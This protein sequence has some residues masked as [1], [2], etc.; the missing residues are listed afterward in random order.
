MLVD[1][2]SDN[3]VTGIA[4]RTKWCPYVAVRCELPSAMVDAIVTTQGSSDPVRN[5]WQL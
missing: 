2:Y 5:Y 4:V 3:T 1:V